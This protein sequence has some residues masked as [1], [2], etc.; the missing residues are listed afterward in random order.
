LLFGDEAQS[1]YEIDIARGRFAWTCGATSDLI[2]WL[3]QPASKDIQHS[4]HYIESSLSLASSM[5]EAGLPV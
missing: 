3:E 4:D 5:L 1:I 2:A